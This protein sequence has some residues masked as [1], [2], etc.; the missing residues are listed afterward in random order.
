MRVHSWKILLDHN[1][2]EKW[3]E[4]EN[5]MIL[6]NELVSLLVKIPGCDLEDISEWLTND[7]VVICVTDND[8]CDSS[9]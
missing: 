4:V 5:S 1:A 9:K 3:E 8:M 2:N 6:N 7:K